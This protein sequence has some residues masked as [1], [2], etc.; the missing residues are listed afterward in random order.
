MLLTHALRA[1]Q[2]DTNTDPFVVGT[3]ETSGSAGTTATVTQPSNTQ[4]GDLLIAIGIGGA[5][6]Y[7]WTSPAGWTERF[8]AEG[9]FISTFEATTAGTVSHVFTQSTS[10][11]RTVI[12]IVV[13]RGVW[14]SRGNIATATTNPIAPSFTVPA[15][16]SLL[17]GIASLVASGTAYTTPAGWTQV[18][19][20]NTHNT[21]YVYTQNALEPS[22]A[23]GTVTFNRASGTGTTSRAQQF[24]I[25]PA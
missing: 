24:S 11:A 16:G 25:S 23:S 4:V 20:R 5:V 18:A 12:L 6:T 19:G 21:L 9:R 7:T 14:G 22:G 8:D 17:F 2:K 13:R 15:N 1:V 10:S 3:F